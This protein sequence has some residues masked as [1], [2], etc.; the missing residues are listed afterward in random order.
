MHI[1][2]LTK[3]KTLKK[4]QLHNKLVGSV[5]MA[6]ETVTLT[7]IFEIPHKI[8][9]QNYIY[10]NT[11]RTQIY[12]I[13]ILTPF[14][15][16]IYCKLNSTS[17]LC[18]HMNYILSSST[19]ILITKWKELSLETWTRWRRPSFHRIWEST[20][21]IW[22][23]WK[24]VV[25]SLCWC[26]YG[27]MFWCW[28]WT[29]LLGRNHIELCTRRPWERRHGATPS[30]AGNSLWLSAKHIGPANSFVLNICVNVP[31]WHNFN[32]SFTFADIF[33]N[34]YIII[35]YRH[36]PLLLYI[37]S[38]CTEMGK[39]TLQLP[40]ACHQWHILDLLFLAMQR[41]LSL[42]SKNKELWGWGSSMGDQTP[43]VAFERDR[44][45]CR[46]RPWLKWSF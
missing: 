8:F 39:L 28:T 6:K 13:Y 17:T 36:L 10:I 20:V 43:L 23:F 22:S 1:L 32:L 45:C 2:T 12:N 31:R 34:L 4:L 11:F 27:T 24:E 40:H 15:L 33:V 21:S 44:P 37:C 26:W 19:R 3:S 42:A 41:R 16:D 46:R 7:L 29:F 38:L 9:I 14:S 35:Q 25:L 18:Y 30:W 5:K